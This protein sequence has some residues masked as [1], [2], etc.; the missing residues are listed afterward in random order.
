MRSAGLAVRVG[1]SRRLSGTQNA[2]SSPPA[3]L[4]AAGARGR[5]GLAA[6]ERGRETGVL[7]SSGAR[8]WNA[9]TAGSCPRRRLLRGVRP[10]ASPAKGCGCCSWSAPRMRG[11]SRSAS[12]G[13]SRSCSQGS[14][15]WLPCLGGGRLLCGF[16][17]N[18][19]APHL[20]S[21]LGGRWSA[22]VKSDRPDVARC[23]RSSRRRLQ[24]GASSSLTR[25]GGRTRRRVPGGGDPPA[26]P[27]DRVRRPSPA[28]GGDDAWRE[29]P[30]ASVPGALLLRLSG[31]RGC[32]RTGCARSRLLSRVAPASFLPSA[33]GS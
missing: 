18:T 7:A 2:V 32:A 16:D 21:R 15:R 9:R 13:G 1:A 27:A 26:P 23:A 5:T 30:L 8:R 25:R 24:A 12:C 31:P 17:E 33:R 29:R 19:P 22:R 6:A 14:R 4:P 3:G 28:R 11:R 10:R 20:C